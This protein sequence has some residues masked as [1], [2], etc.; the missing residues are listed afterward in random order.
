MTVVEQQVKVYKSVKDYRKDVPKMA[1]HGWKVQSSIEENPRSGCGRIL[2]LGFFALL[3][4]PKSKI[5]V[6]YVRETA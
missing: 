3:F 1:R 5:V 4:R 2:M 6:T